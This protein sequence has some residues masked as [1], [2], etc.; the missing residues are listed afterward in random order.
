MRRPK[1]YVLLCG[2]PWFS[3]G[4]AR[5]KSPKAGLAQGAREVK[6]TFGPRNTAKRGPAG[7]SVYAERSGGPL[8]KRSLCTPEAARTIQA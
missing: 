8:A 2:V 6:A 4:L 1:Q 5:G 3:Y 7:G